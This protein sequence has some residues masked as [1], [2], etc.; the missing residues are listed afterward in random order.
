MTKMKIASFLP[1]L[2]VIVSLIFLIQGWLVANI[3]ATSLIS[4]FSIVLTF[5]RKDM[6]KEQGYC[7]FGGIIIVI[8]FLL[9]SSKDFS[10]DHLFQTLFHTSLLSLP[11]V[12]TDKDGRTRLVEFF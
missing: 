12:L 11:L 1:A 10:W 8:F 9:L 3:V 5:K 2:W 6:I 7:L 4:I